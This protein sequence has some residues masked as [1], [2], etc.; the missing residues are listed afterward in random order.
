MFKTF[1][2]FKFLP[3]VRRA[4]KIRNLK[5]VIPVQSTGIRVF[6]NML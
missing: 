4:I 6:G 1:S 3:A 5:F 2:H